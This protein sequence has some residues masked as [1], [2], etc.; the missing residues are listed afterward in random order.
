MF[1]S[2]D[3]KVRRLNAAKPHKYPEERKSDKNV[4]QTHNRLVHKRT[5]NSL[6]RKKKMK[7]RL[8]ARVILNFLFIPLSV[9]SFIKI[10]RDLK[11]F[12]GLL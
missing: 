4:I 6:K 12:V 3:G 10:M 9:I 11:H 8:R 1:H 7:Y 5:L 2:H